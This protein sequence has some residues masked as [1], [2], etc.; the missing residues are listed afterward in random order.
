ML[1]PSSGAPLGNVLVPQPNYLNTNGPA[2]IAPA[3]DPG[4]PLAE[5]IVT[6]QRWAPGGQSQTGGSTVVSADGTEIVVTA[7]RS[8]SDSQATSAIIDSAAFGASSIEARFGAQFL[9]PNG[10]LYISAWANGMGGTVSVRAL[11]RIGG[12]YLF[13]AGFFLD[14]QALI[15][16]D[17]T[18]NHFDLNFV[19][20]AA[21]LTD[22]AVG[23]VLFPDLMIN[24]FYLGGLPT[25]MED[26][27][28]LQ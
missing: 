18:Q 19:M 23:I 24:N 20:G 2:N 7:N 3:A 27:Y 26:T 6:E 11:T 12:G 5:I 21:S 17:I 15:D 1:G 25:F 4:D 10:R 9:G 16:G 8:V 28:Y 22:P 13:A 14:R